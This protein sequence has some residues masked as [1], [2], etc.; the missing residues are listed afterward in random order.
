MA[1][2]SLA[3]DA[4]HSVAA[5]DN[6]S[7]ASPTLLRS[8]SFEE[9]LGGAIV[10][11]SPV[12][13]ETHDSKV[14]KLLSSLAG[15]QQSYDLVEDD[16]YEEY[17]IKPAVKEEA[18]A[19]ITDTTEVAKEDAPMRTASISRQ[20]PLNHPKPDLQSLQG[21]YVKNVER[22]EESAERL[23]MTS[24]LEGEL[25]RMK[26][27]QRRI[28]RS[29]SGSSHAGS[30]RYRA[31]QFSAT[32]ISNSIVEVNAAARSGVYSPAAFITS[33]V[34][35][36]KS[37]RS[38]HG[39]LPDRRSSK[40]SRL[41]NTLP[42]PEL[43]GRPLDFGTSFSPASNHAVLEPGVAVSRSVSNASLVDR[44]ASAAS[45]DTFQQASALFTDFDGVHYNSDRPVG[46]PRQMPLSRPPRA[47]DSRAFRE[48]QP[49]EEMI[50][51]PAPVPVM[52]NLPMRLS[53]MNW[54][55][56]EKKR[57]EALSGMSEDVRKSAIW[58]ASEEGLN[59]TTRQS[60][61]KLP[62]QLR[63]SAFFDYSSKQQNVQLK[64]GSAVATLDSI[65][66]A[67]AYAPVSAFTDHPII[68]QLGKEVYGTQQSR[69]SM[70]M[71]P[72][73]KARR[74]SSFSNLLTRR[75]S[76]NLSTE[77]DRQS[78]VLSGEYD[79][80]DTGRRSGDDLVDEAARSIAPTADE[81]LDHEHVEGESEGDSELEENIQPGFSVAPT[82]LL[83]ELQMRKAQQ[84]LRNRTAADA[85]PNGMHSTLLELDTVTQLQQKARKQK[86]VKLAWED[87]EAADKQ[88]YDDEDIPLGL[89]FSD[90][91]RKDHVNLNRPI[92]L[93]ERRE[94]EENEPLS[95]RRARLRG[96]PLAPPPDVRTIGEYSQA[97]AEQGP[98]VLDIPGLE[99]R[100]KEDDT[101]ES[102]A[103]RLKRMKNRRS[104][105]A[106]SDIARDISNEFG[107]KAASSSNDKTI[108]PDPEETLGQRRKRLKEEAL[109]NGNRDNNGQPAS[110]PALRPSRSLA[111]VLQRN[112]IG[113][114]HSN[115]NKTAIAAMQTFHPVLNR[116]PTFRND[117]GPSMT[118]AY[119]AMQAP[120]ASMNEP[121]SLNYQAH[122]YQPA[123][124]AYL[125]GGM[126]D[127]M[128]AGY[129]A[130]MP[131]NMNMNMAMPM[132]M[133]TG[134]NPMAYPYGM[135]A[136]NQHA[137]AIAM[138]PPLD[139]KQRATIDRWR[140]GIA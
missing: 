76:G 59:N 128:A 7:S 39:S 75:S 103:Q 49:G 9:P 60:M 64:D 106:D 114:Q 134:M 138:G 129:G 107:L 140:Q 3:Q 79:D 27:E 12:R 17:Q 54:S 136:Y 71:Q 29:T 119:N 121:P 131:M 123:M 86:H 97:R 135:A 127:P 24:S 55:E 58:L 63:A 72:E 32:S 2:S 91:D 80:F 30:A 111:D 133:S 36:I 33:P 13:D 120:F 20:L 1:Y 10:D 15:S 110:G 118:A 98:P 101:D 48:P 109:R 95:V 105:G 53:K 69:K 92:G 28:E 51:Y 40:T 65:L 50:Y 115:E 56:R 19:T 88:N 8:Q 96:E 124:P 139:P 116:N 26:M 16:D 122:Q 130:Q 37:P 82:T 99:N 93:M 35:S 89:L 117:Q 94:I 52:L 102:L 46:V 57:L 90:R 67:A 74:R 31:R 108:T 112:P 6:F 77:M 68:G 137:A 73:K 104:N 34:G 23:S 83:A 38:N 66:D 85:F 45:G 21:A 47:R 62:P 81:M 125:G 42:E 43:E 18:M 132:G 78:R 84:K 25:Q 5:M 70:Q 14:S 61:A 41:N 44:P 100:E 4:D 126:Y 113:Y 11:G 87:H 22:L